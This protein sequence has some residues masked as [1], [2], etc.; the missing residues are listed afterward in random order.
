MVPGSSSLA[1]NG[2]EHHGRSGRDRDQRAGPVHG[3]TGCPRSLFAAF[4]RLG[5][6]VAT[7]EDRE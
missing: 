7:E 4:E 2:Y 6:V 3:L 1:V 5:W